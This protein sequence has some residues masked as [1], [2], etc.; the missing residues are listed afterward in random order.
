MADSPKQSVKEDPMV[1]MV[2]KVQALFDE[3]LRVAQ[4]AAVRDGHMPPIVVTLDEVKA[5]HES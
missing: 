1:A 5:L 4:A 3:K 2:P